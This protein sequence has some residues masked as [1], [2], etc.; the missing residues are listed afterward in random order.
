M[1]FMLNY[2][3]LKNTLNNSAAQQGYKITADTTKI[4]QASM[5]NI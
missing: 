5:L 3:I 1:V 2:Y 4:L